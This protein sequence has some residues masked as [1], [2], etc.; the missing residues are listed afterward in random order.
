MG[1]KKNLSDFAPRALAT[2]Y[3]IIRPTVTTSAKPVVASARVIAAEFKRVSMAIHA[4]T[5]ELDRNGLTRSQ[6]ERKTKARAKLMERAYAL[7]DT[8]IHRQNE[9]LNLIQ[10]EHKFQHTRNNYYWF[11]SN[12]AMDKIKSKR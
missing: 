12:G 4:L 1:S 10:G 8:M 5:K 6:I 2:N 11:N 9:G 3:P 7:A